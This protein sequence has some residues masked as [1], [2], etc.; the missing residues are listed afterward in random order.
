MKKRLLLL[1]FVG[2]TAG[3]FAGEESAQEN[4]VE[5]TAEVIKP[6]AIDT[7]AVDF[8]KVAKGTKHLKPKEEGELTITGEAGQS[9]RVQFAANGEQ[10]KNTIGEAIVK[11]KQSGK[12]GE[13]TYTPA[14]ENELDTTLQGGTTTSKIVGTLEVPESADIGIYKGNLKVKVYYN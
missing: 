12:T 10:W 9:I 7:K 2:I 11:L 14:L 6:L 1:C 13:L 4:Q 5:V 8:G 3:L